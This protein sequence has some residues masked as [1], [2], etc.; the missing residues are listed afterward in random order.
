MRYPIVVILML[1][2]CVV[3][4]QITNEQR[5]QID[6]DK[7][8][9]EKVFNQEFNIPDRNKQFV[10]RVPAKL[11]EWFKNFSSSDGFSSIGISDP[12]MDTLPAI[13]LAI[14]RAKALL[15][16]YN[17]SLVEGVNDYYSNKSEL[18]NSGSIFL[19]EK[20]IDYCKIR[21]SINIDT[22]K[23]KVKK[24]T[25]TKYKEAIVLIQYESNDSTEGTEMITVDGSVFM[26]ENQYGNK[27]DYS[28]RF[29]L[30]ITKNSNKYASYQIQEEDK[31]YRFISM[32]MNREVPVEELFYAY[33]YTEEKNGI[34]M[35]YKAKV[36]DGL[37]RSF[38][39]QIMRKMLNIAQ[40][41]NLKIKKVDDVFNNSQNN[42]L[43]R[44]VFKKSDIKYY[45]KS[46]VFSN[47]DFKVNVAMQ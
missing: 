39:K 21:S 27:S 18:K 25:F 41:E 13:E 23:L 16:F 12:G 33:L 31:R 30:D 47:N 4:A 1:L 17:N 11:P 26:V 32:F 7:K 46:V 3:S 5:E 36:P 10:D 43:I 22:S 2:S 45:L 29:E 37:W 9:F 19:R 34:S 28:A 24:I 8:N 6:R 35:S 14:S 42:Y 15:S 20:Y 44:E 40:V 38:L